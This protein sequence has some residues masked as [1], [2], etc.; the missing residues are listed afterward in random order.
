MTNKLKSF[1]LIE[2]LLVLLITASIIFMGAVQFQTI[3][4][5]FIENHFIQAFEARYLYAQKMSVITG[6][7]T[8]LY[9][10]TKKIPQKISCGVP[11]SGVR[12]ERFMLPLPETIFVKSGPKE[13]VFN[14]ESGRSGRLV[15]YIFRLNIN[16]KDVQYV[17][18]MG[19]GKYVKTEQK[20]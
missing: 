15:T 1:T 7:D 14:K 12:T 4:A 19:D 8:I 17:L 5:T 18:Q 6:E 2:Q 10:E 9:V 11:I 20:F 16:K 3:K 13:L